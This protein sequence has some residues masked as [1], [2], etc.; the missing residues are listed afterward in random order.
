MDPKTQQEITCRL[1]S[2]EGHIRGILRMVEED[3]PCTAILQQLQAVQGSLKQ[4][5][6]LLI[7]QQLD[8][9]LCNLDG[10]ETKRGHALREELFALFE[11]NT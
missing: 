8:R 4:V 2:S 7:R 5:Q 3:R 6:L 1:R 11:H 10:D 9:C